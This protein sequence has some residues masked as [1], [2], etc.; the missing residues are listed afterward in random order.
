MVQTSVGRT[1]H[2]QMSL[3]AIQRF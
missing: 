1:T 3:A 2:T